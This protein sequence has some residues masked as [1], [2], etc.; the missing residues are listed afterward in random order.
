MFAGFAILIFV[1]LLVHQR[2]S[3][4]RIPQPIF[5]TE[6]IPFVSHAIGIARHGALYYKSIRFVKM[7][8]MNRQD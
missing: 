5:I 4:R 1:L 7:Y 8:I 3:K 6:N 2:R